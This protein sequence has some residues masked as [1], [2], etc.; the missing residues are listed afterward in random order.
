[1]GDPGSLINGKLNKK[2]QKNVPCHY[3]LRVY[4]EQNH[5]L[6]ILSRNSDLFHIYD[7]CFHYF[8]EVQE[9]KPRA[10]IENP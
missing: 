4:F 1:M 2:N 3:F 10:P 9:K 7:F 8:L 6:F 5:A